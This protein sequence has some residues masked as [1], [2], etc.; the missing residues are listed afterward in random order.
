MLESDFPSEDVCLILDQQLPGISGIEALE[1]LRARGVDAPTFLMT[2]QPGARL[3][4]R[5]KAARACILEK[6]ILG[7]ALV[8]AIRNLSPG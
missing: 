2:T 3:R 6:P 7:D 5:A 4:A 8:V 1:V